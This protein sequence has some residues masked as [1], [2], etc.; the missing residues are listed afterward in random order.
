[1]VIAMKVKLKTKI[2]ALAI[3]P[4]CVPLMTI[5]LLT[6]IFYSI[7]LLTEE[8]G[9]FFD[10]IDSYIAIKFKKFIKWVNQ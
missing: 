8:V 3:L 2:V 1:V 5:G 6:K 10:R 7:S 9:A 4:L